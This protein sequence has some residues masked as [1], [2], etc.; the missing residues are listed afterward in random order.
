[1]DKLDP[2]SRA[3]SCSVKARVQISWLVFPSD[4]VTQSFAEASSLVSFDLCRVPQFSLFSVVHVNDSASFNPFLHTL[5][6]QNVFSFDT[7]LN[8]VAVISF[9]GLLSIPGPV[10]VSTVCVVGF[11]VVLGDVLR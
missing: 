5:Q 9:S 2:A 10:S 6:E 4:S 3:S 11:A 8:S 1:M 7:K